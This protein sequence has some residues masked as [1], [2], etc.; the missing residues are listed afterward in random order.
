MVSSKMSQL[1]DHELI[2]IEKVLRQELATESSNA[3]K[4]LI[5][6]CINAIKSQRDI[7]TTLSVK[8]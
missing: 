2:Y 1:S 8:W 6:N 4:R 3:Q 7:T 5:L